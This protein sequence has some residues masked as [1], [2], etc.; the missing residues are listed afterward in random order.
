MAGQKE[1]KDSSNS[2]EIICVKACGSLVCTNAFS[3]IRAAGEE[4]HIQLCRIC[5][6]GADGHSWTEPKGKLLGIYLNE[7]DDT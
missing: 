5:G 3:R 4:D 6:V 1:G 2:I 7:N